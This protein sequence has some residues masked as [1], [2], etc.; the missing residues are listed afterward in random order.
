MNLE[1]GPT[2]TSGGGVNVSSADPSGARIALSD[3]HSYGVAVASISRILQGLSGK[4]RLRALRAVSGEFGHRV[5][6]GLGTQGPIRNLSVPPVGSRPKAPIQPRS[7][8][9]AEQK[10][11]DSKIKELNSK[12]KEK[13]AHLGVPL[14]ETDIL[15]RER[16]RLFRAKHGKEASPVTPHSGEGSSDS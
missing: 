2:P 12:I 3:D 8:K 11:I 7:T 4:D 14:S 16:Q 6:P 13:S 15:L 1:N 5:L 9:T 10:R